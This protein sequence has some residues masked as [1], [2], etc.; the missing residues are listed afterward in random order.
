MAAEASRS[1]DEWELEEDELIAIDMTRLKDV[2]ADLKDML[3]AE[4]KAAISK[5]G[6][7]VRQESFVSAQCDRALLWARTN[8]KD[9]LYEAETAPLPCTALYFS[10]KDDNFKYQKSE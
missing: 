1:D 3:P 9:N 2:H 7:S 10:I 8:N 5:L 6:A 4:R